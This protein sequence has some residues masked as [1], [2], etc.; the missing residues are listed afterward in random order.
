MLTCFNELIVSHTRIIECR[1]VSL[2]SHKDA[3]L[4]YIY[5]ALICK[6]VIYSISRISR[7]I[8]MIWI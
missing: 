1:S 5:T 4:V 6:V 7:I 8:N 3:D 2:T